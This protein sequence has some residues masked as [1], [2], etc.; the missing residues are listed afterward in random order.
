[1][2]KNVDEDNGN[3]EEE[4]EE[5]LGDDVKLKPLL[6]IKTKHGVIP[7]SRIDEGNHVFIFIFLVFNNN[8]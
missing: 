4:Y 3:I 7:Q 2:N 8:C 6:P 1:M 5:T